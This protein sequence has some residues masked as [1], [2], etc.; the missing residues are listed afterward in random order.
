MNEMR[1]LM[2]T[3]EPLYDE[4]FASSIGAY[5]FDGSDAD[6]AEIGFF[7]K[8]R[9]RSLHKKYKAKFVFAKVHNLSDTIINKTRDLAEYY[10]YLAGENDISERNLRR[11]MRQYEFD[12]KGRVIEA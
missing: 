8:L 3:V 11:I 4:R 12:N 1:K 5:G 2:E 10:G 6:P 9:Y 7:E